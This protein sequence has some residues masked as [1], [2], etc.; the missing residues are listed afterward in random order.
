MSLMKRSRAPAVATQ[1][2]TPQQM[3]WCIAV[4]LLVCLL[5]VAL[6][7]FR[8]SSEKTTVSV[9]QPPPARTFKAEQFDTSREAIP[10]L[11][12]R[13]R[14]VI[15]ENDKQYLAPGINKA[16]RIRQAP[17]SGATVGQLY[18]QL[19]SRQIQHAD[20]ERLAEFSHK[21]INECWRFLQP[22]GQGSLSPF[23]RP[24]VCEDI[25]A[26]AVARNA[27]WIERL[28]A[29]GNA[30]GLLLYVGR[31]NEDPQRGAALQ[32]QGEEAIRAFHARQKQ[33]LESL[34]AEG[35]YQA[36]VGLSLHYLNP[37]TGAAS[38]FNAES[39]YLAS[40]MAKG[41]PAD[42]N[43]ALERLRRTVSDEEKREAVIRRAQRIYQ[44]CCEGKS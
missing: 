25:P 21:L 22:T 20:A 36:L 40:E 7:V 41:S 27:E 8:G 6:Q 17:D 10:P 28:A 30:R 31:E 14:L 26:D 42:L 24:D 11:N 32:Q 9:A 35:N 1:Q 23:A 2:R 43:A 16:W 5:L 18:A 19:A 33:A 15:S 38:A 3:L 34:A 13:L 39:F 12:Q 37:A 29:M 44:R 4:A